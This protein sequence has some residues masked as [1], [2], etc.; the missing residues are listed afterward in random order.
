M[1]R[2]DLP[3]P[4]HIRSPPPPQPIRQREGIFRVA[5]RG[6]ATDGERFIANWRTIVECLLAALTHPG[7]PITDRQV[8][9]FIPLVTSQCW[10][11]R[12]QAI[13][14][15]QKGL[16]ELT[17]N[18]EQLIQAELAL[19]GRLDIIA[20]KL[21]SYARQFRR[22]IPR[23]YFSRVTYRAGPRY[24]LLGDRRRQIREG[25]AYEATTGP[26]RPNEI[27]LDARLLSRRRPVSK[28]LRGITTR[29]SLFPR[30]TQL[31]PKNSAAGNPVIFGNAFV[32]PWRGRLTARGPPPALRKEGA[33]PV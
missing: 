12:A 8:A 2:E 32:R 5:R 17:N 27:G 7:A 13:H 14:E 3:G 31:S 22:A 20:N 16:Y 25:K 6:A 1:L 19:R 33:P 18:A 26:S 15:L 30:A 28:N 10:R 4:S 21:G 29:G 24:R 11:S 23:S 9:K